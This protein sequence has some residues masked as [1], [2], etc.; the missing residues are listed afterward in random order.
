MLTPGISVYLFALRP[1]IFQLCTPFVNAAAQ[2]AVSYV[3]F[4]VEQQTK[5][6]K[7]QYK[8]KDSQRK[9]LQ[10]FQLKH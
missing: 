8:L 9:T 7:D 10:T 1:I 2:H 3:V 5:K 6:N 4:D